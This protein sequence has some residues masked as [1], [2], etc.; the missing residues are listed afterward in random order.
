VGLAAAR[1][2]T[3]AVAPS[4]WGPNLAAL[5]RRGLTIS[6]LAVHGDGTIDLD[7]LQRQL[8]ARPPAFVHPTQMASHRPLV[9]P[10]REAAVLC[11]AAGV[12]LWV[13]AAQALGHVDTSCGADVVYATS[14]KWL[15][16]P[17]GVGVL[18]AA[19]RWWDRLRPD[20]CPLARPVPASDDAGPRGKGDP[21]RK[22]D[23]GDAGPGRKGD[24][25]GTGNLGGDAG[26]VRLLEPTEASVAGRVGLCA[27]VREYL[28]AGPPEVWQRLAQ[29][30]TLTREILGGLPGWEVI[31]PAEQRRQPTLGQRTAGP[32]ARPPT[33]ARR[34]PALCTWNSGRSRPARDAHRQVGTAGHTDIPTPP[35]HQ[36]LP[37][38]TGV[39]SPRVRSGGTASLAR[40]AITSFRRCIQVLLPGARF[41]ADDLVA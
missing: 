26:P 7:H 12:P 16:G 23:P 4:E 2:D 32:A 40:R 3:V 28:D 15:T 38:E 14:R 5:T 33:A 9:Q 24:S 8:D 21:G 27:A 17:R 35:R 29:V 18:A 10:V 1:R 13:D 39:S 20:A 30:G 22:G 34:V 25:G 11:R 41:S 6:Q 37:P 36:H 19:A 31:A